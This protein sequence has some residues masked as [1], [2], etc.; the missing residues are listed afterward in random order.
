MEEKKMQELNLNEM[1]KVSGGGG[2]ENWDENGLY[3][4][5]DRCGRKIYPD[6]F[7]GTLTFY[8]N[9]CKTTAVMP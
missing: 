6:R 8:C 5:C 3:I 4:I 1:E 2:D 9:N 7:G